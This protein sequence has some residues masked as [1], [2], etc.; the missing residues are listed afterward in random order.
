MSWLIR[1]L[2]AWPLHDL[3]SYKLMRANVLH[4]LRI[5]DRA[6]GWTAE[7]LAK[8][9]ARRLNLAEVETGYR[10]RIGV[11]KVSGSVHGSLRAAWQ[12]NAAILRVWRQA[13]RAKAS[14]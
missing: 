3:A 4:S 13:K 2:F 12:L 14:G 11:S 1:R 6:Q 9:A 5:E 8:A 10:R 7:L